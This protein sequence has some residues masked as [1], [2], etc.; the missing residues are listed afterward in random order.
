MK[1]FNLPDMQ[2][3][4][5]V[6]CTYIIEG[7]SYN[8]R[9]TWCDTFFLLD[10]Y[11][12]QNETERYLYKGLPIVCGV[13]IVNRIKNPELIEGS[14]VIKNKFDEDVDPSPENFKSDFELIY[15]GQNN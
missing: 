3:N 14:L 5:R 12:I 6:F 10:V 8:F 7:K 1:K 11:I 4:S 15:Y 2:T 13:N 9:F